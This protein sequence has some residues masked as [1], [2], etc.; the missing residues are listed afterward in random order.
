MKAVRIHRLEG[1]DALQLED[2]PALKPKRGMVR[3]AVHAAGVNFADTLAVQGRYQHKQPLPFTPGME[4]AGEVIELGEGVEGLT[5]GTR[6][7][8]PMRAGAW[9]EEALCEAVHAIPMPDNMDY[10]TGAAFSLNYGTSHLALTHRVKLGAGQTLLVLGASGGVGLTAVEIGKVL[11]ATVIAAASSPEK[12]EIA[13]AAGADHAVDYSAQDLRET[14]LGLS[15]G[16]DAVYDPVGGELSRQALRCIN[17]E[18]NLIVVGFASGDIPQI[19]QNYLLVKNIAAV[20]YS[21]STYRFQRPE[22]MRR[23]LLELADWYAAGR[24][25][26]HVSH[27]FPLARIG[28]ALRTITG[29]ASTGKVVLT[30]RG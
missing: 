6:V 25:H 26:P 12:L 4:V 19:P 20:G 8:A 3:I 2:V 10:V 30:V 22:L 14:V 9:A 5:V 23:S 11:G 21:W 18:G 27:S 16:V 24:L 28:D 17:Y 7:M 15:G 1:I 29:R 13:K